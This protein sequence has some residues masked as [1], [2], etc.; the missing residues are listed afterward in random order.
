MSV[1]RHIA[2]IPSG[3][4]RWAHSRDMDT[5]HGHAIGVSGLVELVEDAWAQ[6][7]ECVTVWL[8]NREDFEVRRRVEVGVLADWLATD[9]ASLVERNDAVAEVLGEWEDVSPQIGVAV[10]M[11]LDA[12]GEGPR[13]LVLLAAFDG[14]RE[15]MAA[16]RRVETTD[17]A[18][19]QAALTTGHLPPIDLVVRTGDAG[20]LVPG[21]PLWHL[22]GAFMHFCPFPWPEFEIAD[23]RKAIASWHSS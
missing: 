9:G 7:V 16:A 18:A 19:F 22:D 20:C 6:G 17:P 5:L 2:L 13:R 10:N 21:F 4:R 11:M 12:S 14:R 3:T 8:G 1:P 23:L 15:M